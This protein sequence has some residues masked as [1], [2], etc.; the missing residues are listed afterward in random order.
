[1]VC[2]GVPPPVGVRWHRVDQGL[3]LRS[4]HACG[5]GASPS[6]LCR[7]LVV[8]IF[9]PRVRGRVVGWCVVPPCIFGASS[10]LH[11]SRV[12]LCGCLVPCGSHP[13]CCR[14]VLR[15]ACC[16]GMAPLIG[17]GGVGLGLSSSCRQW[18]L[19]RGLRGRVL[20]LLRLRWWLAGG[21]CGCGAVRRC[22]L[23]GGSSRGVAL[24]VPWFGS[25]RSVSG[26][27]VLWSG[28]VSSSWGVL[29]GLGCGCPCFWCAVCRGLWW[30]LRSCWVSPFR[31][32]LLVWGCGGPR[33]CCAVC[34]GLWL[35]SR[36][37]W[38]LLSGGVLLVW[39]GGCLR[40]CCAT[41]RWR[42]LLW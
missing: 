7:G 25:P 11:P 33:C 10:R 18:P 1:M 13:C 30:L 5:R 39:G 31:G 9:V 34:R 42:W 28:R 14:W 3:R 4:P 36:P 29:P 40:C 19:C 20:P 21:C 12:L 37:C 32:V 27:R 6:L 38:V 35:L 22:G 41:S 15:L 17:H 26:H 24:L 8:F 16:C 2:E 23:R